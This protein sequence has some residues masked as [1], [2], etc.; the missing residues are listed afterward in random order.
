[1]KQLSVFDRIAILEAKAEKL[2]E[3][4]QQQARVLRAA[5]LTPEAAKSKAVQVPL[6]LKKM[7]KICREVCLANEL[8][9]AELRGPSRCR[10]VAWPRQDAMRL[11]QDAGFSLP[12]IGRY[13]GGRDHTTI[14]EGIRASKA[15]EAE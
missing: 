15:R 12:E 1:M 3:I 8:S 7:Q 14:L 2:E 5:G 6:R 11:L 9:L 13:L 10:Y 4:V